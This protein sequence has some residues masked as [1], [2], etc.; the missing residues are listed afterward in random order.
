MKYESASLLL[1]T[2]KGAI[3]QRLHVWPGDV[4]DNLREA[5]HAVELVDEGEVA[6]EDVEEAG[7]VP[8]LGAV[9]VVHREAQEAGGRQHHRAPQGHQVHS[10]V[11]DGGRGGS[12][13]CVWCH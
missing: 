6:V 1:S 7:V 8:V 3:K 4:L 2:R 11:Q 5:D 13:A 9:A 12:V 10:R